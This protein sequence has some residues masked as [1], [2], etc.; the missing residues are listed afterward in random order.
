[1]SLGS[2]LEVARPGTFNLTEALLSDQHD[3]P[4]PLSRCLKGQHQT[5]KAN[6]TSDE[7]LASRSQPLDHD[8]VWSPGGE[9]ANPHGLVPGH[10]GHVAKGP[11]E[12]LVNEKAQTR[13]PQA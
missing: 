11:R 1:M 2:M 7:S 13:R 8:R 9:V 3:S 12:I 5:R 6:I 4:E 10:S